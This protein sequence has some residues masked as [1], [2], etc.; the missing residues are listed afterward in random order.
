MGGQSAIDEAIR[1]LAARQ[2][3]LVAR[4]Q[5]LRLGL[6]GKA[7][8]YRIRM[9]RLIGVERGVYALGHAELRPEGRV[10]AVVLSCGDDAVLSHRSAAALW[11]MRPRSGAFVEVTVAG[12]GG[13]KERAGVRVHRSVDL[14][15]NEIAT[16]SAI[17]TT[18]PP[19]TL[20]DLAAVVPAHHLRRA[21]ERADELELFDLSEIE[22]VLEAHP[23]RPGRRA[24]TALLDDLRTY[25]TTPT[26][27]DLEAAMLQLCLDRRLP[28]PQVNRHDGTR[29]VDFRW[30]SHRLIVE[31]DGWAYH[32]TRA[33]FDD[34]RAR[35]RALLRAGWRVARFSDRQVARDPDAVAA[36]L[37][38]LLASEQGS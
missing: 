3:G 31:V 35:D 30:P 25:G 28:R 6:G 29:E 5:L 12:D 17:P 2:H 37:A 22:R 15:P 20:L 34:D 23:R 1:R 27:S 32:R 13:Q 16:E 11:G 9:K 36:D 7:I 18:T 14:P 10:L 4:R 33:A 19:R 38:S 21:V 26:R 8:D 24:L